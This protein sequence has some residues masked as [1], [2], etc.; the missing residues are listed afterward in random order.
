MFKSVSIYMNFSALIQSWW[1]K[2]GPNTCH[3]PFYSW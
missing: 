2:S 3:R 1:R